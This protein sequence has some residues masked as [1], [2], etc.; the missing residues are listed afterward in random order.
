MKR[1][2]E[3]EDDKVVVG[4]MQNKNMRRKFGRFD[5]GEI[6][7]RRCVV[8]VKEIILWTDST[9]EEFNVPYE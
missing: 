8:A 1:E 7:S 5:L 9:V 2:I 6:R 4:E 3:T